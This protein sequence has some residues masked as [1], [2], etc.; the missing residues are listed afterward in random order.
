MAFVVDVPMA[1]VEADPLGLAVD[2]PKAH[3]LG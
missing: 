3:G 1:L 2:A